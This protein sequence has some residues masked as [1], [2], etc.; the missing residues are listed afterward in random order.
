MCIKWATFASI[1]SSHQIVN[2][3]NHLFVLHSQIVLLEIREGDFVLSRLKMKEQKNMGIYWTR[4]GKGR[5]GGF[6]GCIRDL[7]ID[8]EF[9]DIFKLG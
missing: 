5:A 3:I 1:D 4:I 8:G 6:T 9:T 7:F 2:D